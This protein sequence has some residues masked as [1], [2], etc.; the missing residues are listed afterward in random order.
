MFYDVTETEVQ[1]LAITKADAQAWLDEEG[2]S[3]DSAEGS[4][5]GGGEG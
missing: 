4:G 2:I 3:E 5:A 1:V